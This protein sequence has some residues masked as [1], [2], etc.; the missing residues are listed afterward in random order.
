MNMCL[1]DTDIP[2][3]MIKEKTTLIQKDQENE[4]SQQLR[5]DNV[6]NNYVANTN[7]TNRSSIL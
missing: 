5:T 4:P 3:W 7:G 1:Q 6:H 2:E